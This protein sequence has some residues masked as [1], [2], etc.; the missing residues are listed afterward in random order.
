MPNRNLPSRAPAH[1]R[2]ASLPWWGALCF[3]AS[4]AAGLLYEVVWSKE[5]SY[6]LGNSLHAVATVV[7]A[8]L[9]GLALGAR[10]L[11]PALGRRGDGARVYAA[12]EIGVAVLGIVSLPILRGL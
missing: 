11:G 10:F 6:L 3:F 1:P 8:F 9:G 12:L 4:G 5:L 2:A 7:A